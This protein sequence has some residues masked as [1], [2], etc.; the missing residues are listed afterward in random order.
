MN[1][2]ICGVCPHHCRLTEG[3][4]GFCRAR[5][6]R[7]G[8]IIPENYG[9]LTAVSMD[10]IEKKPF[11]RYYPGSLILSVGSY[12]CNLRCPF[13]QN[14]AISQTGGQHIDYRDVKPGELASLT[15]GIPDNLGIAFTYNEPL[16]S[17]EY[18]R[19]TGRILR[20]KAPKKKIVLVSNGMASPEVM[21]ALLPYTDAANIDLKGDADFYRQELDGSLQTVMDTIALLAANCHLEITTLVITGKNDSDEWIS[22]EATWIASVDADIPLHLSRCFPRY[23]SNIPA[24]PRE[25]VRRL[26]QT[27]EKYLKYVYTGNM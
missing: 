7:N 6:C 19:D 14:A 25:T 11:A 3:K 23:H 21:E 1:E 24:T 8:R 26:K 16:I 22:R 12:G 27:A 10:P 17:W 18:I 20:Q 5:R 2:M 13:C 15:A 9:R 4:Y